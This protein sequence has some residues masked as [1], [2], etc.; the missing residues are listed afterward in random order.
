ML[1][2]LYLYIRYIILQNTRFDILYILGRSLVKNEVENKIS[3]YLSYSLKS[4]WYIHT[5]YCYYTLHDYE[6][7]YNN[8]INFIYM[9]YCRIGWFVEGDF[10]VSIV[11]YNTLYT[12][13]YKLLQNYY[14]AKKKSP[15]VIIIFTLLNSLRF[16][17]V[18][19]IMYM[20]L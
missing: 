18:R 19:T 16:D 11:H 3:F 20:H 9:K 13:T 14:S 1:R 8:F 5:N 17:R 15:L 12:D 4:C 10:L 7:I 2:Y 6:Y